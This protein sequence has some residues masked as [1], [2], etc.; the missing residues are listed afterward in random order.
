M[1]APGKYLANKLT[2]RYSETID[3]IEQHRGQWILHSQESGDLSDTYD[4]VMIALPAPQAATLVNSQNQ[5]IERLTQLATMQGSWTLMVQ[6][7]NNP[8]VHFDAAFIN[9]E[10]ISWICN[11]QSKPGREGLET[12][13]IQASAAWSQQWLELDK[14][15]ATQEILQCLS[16]LGFDCQ[17]AVATS[18]RWRYATGY[19]NRPPEYYFSKASQ[20]G[21]CGDWLHGGKVEG[22]WLSGYQLANKLKSVL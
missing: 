9:Q 16:Q 12:W 5:E 17:D 1:S 7:K 14:D 3:Q 20:L 11:N 10:I 21:L 8:S 4:Y 15:Q 18:H 19:I 2:V 13:T 22:A 6:F